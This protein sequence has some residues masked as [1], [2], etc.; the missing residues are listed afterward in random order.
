MAT[1]V[2]TR[3]SLIDQI[4]SEEDRQAPAARPQS[5]IHSSE[6]GRQVYNT[7]MALPGIGGV[8]KVA[9]TGGLVSRAL[10]ATAGAANKLATGTAAL[11]ALPAGAQSAPSTPSVPSSGAAATGTGTEQTPDTNT[12][13]PQTEEPARQVAP[14]IYRVGNSYAGTGEAAVSLNNAPRGV[15]SAQNMAAADQLAA[16]Q[17]MESAARVARSSQPQVQPQS[18]MGHVTA[19][20]SG[21]DWTT[22]EN[23][24]RLKMDA[25][26]LIH[27]SAWAPK[28]SGHAAQH[29]YANAAAADLAAMSGGQTAADIEVMK[30][31]AGLQRE[32]LQQSGADRRDGRRSLVEMARLGMDQETQGFA[33][34][35]AAQQEQLRNTL[36]NPNATPEQRAVAQRSLAALAGKTAADRMQTVTLPDTTND[37]GQVVRGGQALVRLMEDGSVQQVPVSASRPTGAASSVQREVGTVSRVGNK[38]AVWDGSKWVP[39]Q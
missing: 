39:R 8:G 20:H 21:N 32:Q 5:G 29:A 14:G 38:E 33:N 16:N 28:G 12:A 25:T 1:S 23:L 18:L 15:P 9:Q 11:A 17:Q 10:N 30:Q 24:R 34:R 22:R 13:A 4:P 37:M 7:A 31:N 26:S 36:I 3:R 27:Q 6:L 2:L 35:A 19:T